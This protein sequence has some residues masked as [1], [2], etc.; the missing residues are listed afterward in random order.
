MFFNWFADPRLICLMLLYRN[1]E[2]RLAMVDVLQAPMLSTKMAAF[3]Q[4]YRPKSMEERLRRAHCRIVEA[5]IEGIVR[6]SNGLLSMT[7]TPHHGIQ[8]SFDQLSR[9]PSE[10]G[11]KV[12]R[13]SALG[14]DAFTQV[15][16][17]FFFGRGE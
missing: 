11:G 6:S 8:L 15:S 16:G 13:V 14:M 9:Q 4:S 2:D 5:Q 1:V 10:V 12:A 7:S 3:P 17:K